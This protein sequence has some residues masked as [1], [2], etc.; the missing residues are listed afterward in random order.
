M[1]DV[2]D[3]GLPATERC[4]MAALAELFNAAAEQGFQAMPNRAPAADL[5]AARHC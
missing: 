2:A 5:L 4:R 1:H 3:Q